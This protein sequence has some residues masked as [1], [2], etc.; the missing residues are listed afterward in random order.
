MNP[1][2]PAAVACAIGLAQGPA[3]GATLE[4]HTTAID[5]KQR[6]ALTSSAT[7]APGTQPPEGDIS[8]FVDPARTYQP[9]LGIGGAI[10]DASAEV[11]ARLSAKEQERLLRAYYDPVD[12]IG[13][14]LA[15][16]T[17]HSSD[18]SSASY[19]YIAEGDAGLTSF[20]IAHDR[21]FR[22]PLIKRAIAA[23][24]GHLTLFASPWSAPAFMKTN[25]S[26]LQGGKLRPEFANAWARY[27]TRF[28][29]AYEHEGITVWGITIQNEPMATQRWESMIY[30]AEDERDFLKNH[31]GPAMAQAGLGDR[32]II[33]WDH[34]RDLMTQR[35]RV[36]FE[37]P[38][39]SKYAWGMGFH[40][41]ETW[42]GGAPM[43][44]NVA[45]V[46]RA[47]PDKHLLLTEAAVEGFDPARLQ[48]VA[49]AER[50]G[51]AL[52]NDFNNGA[53]G[54]TDWNILL[55]EHGGP[56]H[57]G[58]F[59]FAPVHA[60]SRTGELTFTPS[61]WYLGH[62]SKFIRP[63]AHRVEAASSR[64][65]LATTSWANPDGSL[66][67]VVMNATD[68]PVDYRFFVGH[69]EARVAIPAHAIQTLVVR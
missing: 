18:F 24:G 13:Y 36:I 15:R 59:C 1:A 14:S 25:A 8:V 39:A 17:I 68:Q 26:M 32:R 27:Y 2:I 29:R 52:I 45:A 65:S 62:F 55:D 49:N 67:T 23:A 61:F 38:D 34:N 7:L 22:I 9:L 63:G 41:Y 69:D 31:L 40:W 12:G 10:T 19:T 51:T 35:A 50:Y 60:D 11:F 42:T 53:E 3:H 57:V 44:A 5:G 21:E 48:S 56:N 20:S 58:N 16:T 4:V 43:F 64:S 66:A 33:V 37:D 28:I 54:W 47:W 30:S 6:L 46:Q